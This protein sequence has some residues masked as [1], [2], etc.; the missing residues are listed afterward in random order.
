MTSEPGFSQSRPIRVVGYVDGYNVYYGLRDKGW[1]RYLWLD[2]RALFQ[3][4][5]R[6]GYE[7][8]ALKYFTS[9]GRRQSVASHQRQ[10]LYLDA[11]RAHGGAEVNVSGNFTMKRWKCPSCETWH[12]RPQEKRTDVAIG[13]QMV[14]DAYEDRFDAAWLMS[15][16]SNLIPAVSMVREQFPEKVVSILI[17]RGRRSQKLVDTADTAWHLERRRWNQ[18][19]LPD[20]VITEDGTVYACPAEWQST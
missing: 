16:D 18:A 3:S 20:P 9:L 19:R 8:I 10:F 1:E 2:Y 12:K 6:T 13:V 15:A 17:P 7:L 5:I 11:L 4:Q 14:A